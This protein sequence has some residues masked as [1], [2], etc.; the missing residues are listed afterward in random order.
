M[1]TCLCC[2]LCVLASSAVGCPR[3]AALEQRMSFLLRCMKHVGHSTMKGTHA[4]R[5]GAAA[6]IG[7][8][9]AVG[10]PPTFRSTPVSQFCYCDSWTG[11]ASVGQTQQ[12]A[13]GGGWTPLCRYFGKCGHVG[14]RMWVAWRAVDGPRNT[15]QTR[16]EQSR[17]DKTGQRTEDGRRSTEDGGWRTEDRG[18]RTIRTEDRGGGSRRLGGGLHNVWCR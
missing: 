14:G 16:A 12:T 11:S 6:A 9:S 4:A 3:C 10:S 5:K 7:D 2:C 15:D 1:F 17:A 8:S 13:V 18:L